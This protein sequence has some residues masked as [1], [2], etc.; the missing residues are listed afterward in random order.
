MNDP[1]LEE[2]V[3]SALGNLC[4]ILCFLG[5]S[6]G[7]LELEDD[8]DG[9]ESGLSMFITIWSPLF[10]GSFEKALTTLTPSQRGVLDLDT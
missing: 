5:S 9:L 1:V 2:V 4:L 6:L 8:N 3:V 7:K 10:L